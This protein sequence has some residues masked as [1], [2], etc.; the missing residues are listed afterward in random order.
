M[1]KKTAYMR[2]NLSIY[3]IVF[4]DFTRLKYIFVKGGFNFQE[5]L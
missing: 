2:S 3:V 1:D 4:I 5:M